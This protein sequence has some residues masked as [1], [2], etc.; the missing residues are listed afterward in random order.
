MKS[1]NINK[2]NINVKY[3]YVK[4]GFLKTL[5]YTQ[6]TCYSTDMDTSGRHEMKGQGGGGSIPK[7]SVG[8]P[9]ISQQSNEMSGEGAFKSNAMKNSLWCEPYQV[10][11]SLSTV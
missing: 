7:S 2:Y 8:Q 3:K 4:S 11:C 1:V 6:M 10:S 9:P 5:H